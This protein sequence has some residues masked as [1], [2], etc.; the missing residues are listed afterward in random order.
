MGNFPPKNVD[1]INYSFVNQ[2]Y[3][4]SPEEITAMLFTRLKKTA[5]KALKIKINHAIIACP[6]YFN[7]NARTAIKEAAAIAGK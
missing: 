5:E 7:E 3:F 2:D 6:T 4:L 1:K